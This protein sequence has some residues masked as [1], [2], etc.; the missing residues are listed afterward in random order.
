MRMYLGGEFG[1]HPEDV[2]AYAASSFYAVDR[3]ASWKKVWQRWYERGGLVLTDR[4]TTSNAVHQ[5]SKLPDEEK[6]PFFRWLADFEY[7]RL[8]LPEPDLVLY[9]DMPTDQ[10]MTMLRQRE[11]ATHTKG[12]IHETDGAYLAACRQA[13]RQA[14]D[15]YGWHTIPCLDEHG[16]LRD[17]DTIHEALWQAALPLLTQEGENDGNTSF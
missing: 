5:G 6:G 2:N 4:Y 12:D 16:R 13:A 7:R 1:K 11:A 17:I 10:A 9:L 8:G 3:Y 15:L 14:A